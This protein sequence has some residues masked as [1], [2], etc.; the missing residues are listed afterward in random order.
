M[1]NIK[2][3]NDFVE[4]QILRS[5]E[6]SKLIISDLFSDRSRDMDTILEMLQELSDDNILF[7]HEAYIINIDDGTNQREYLD[8]LYDTECID[9]NLY[10]EFNKNFNLLDIIESYVSKLSDKSKRRI[11]NLWKSNSNI[12]VLLTVDGECE[13]LF[14][15]LRSHFT[16]FQVSF[17]KPYRIIIEMK[18]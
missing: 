2:T 4:N 1:D 14:K 17:S 9:E 15:R 10:D 6:L 7:D 8:T 18:Y 5:N 12:R 16:Q 11:F 3:F 13:E